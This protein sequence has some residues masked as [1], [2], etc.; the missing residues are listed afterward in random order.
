MAD[1]RLS[2]WTK[3]A[4]G[5]GDLGTGM[6]ANILIFFLLPFLTNTVGLAAGLAGSIYAITRFWDALNDP[7]IGILSDRTRSRWGR[8]RPWLLFSALPFALTFAAQWWIPF[9]GRTGLLSAYYLAV[10]LLFNTFYSAANIPYASLTAELTQD[11][12]ERTQLNQF[13]FAFS[14]GGS[15][16]AVVTFPLLVNLL[17][18]RAAGHL[19]AGACFGVISALP[20]LL[21]FWGVREQYQSWR[22]PLPLLQQL[23]VAFSN[24]PYL[25]VSGIYLCSWLAFQFTATIIPY[26]I[27]FWMQL[28]EVWISLVVLAVQSVAVLTLF[29]WTRLS[30]H[31]GKRAMYLIGAGFWLISQAGLFFLQPGQERLMIALALLAGV[32]VSA[33]AYLGPWS[34]LPDVIDLDEL[35]TGERREGIFYALMVFLQKVGLGLGLFFLGQVLEWSGFIPSVAGEPPPTQPESALLAIRL[36]IGPLPAVVLIGGILLVWLYPITRQRH[37]QILQELEARRAGSQPAH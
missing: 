7:L 33:T 3:L 30:A 32:G 28:P 17:P 36:A 31:L 23:R 10:S 29:A 35:H 12:D 22:D 4:Y 5:V 21:C 6:T 37:R 2:W 1:R 24:R 34:M 15:M 13:R 27:V 16:V 11:Y 14:V 20:L 26:F 8:R 25:F 19:L 18:D 9:P